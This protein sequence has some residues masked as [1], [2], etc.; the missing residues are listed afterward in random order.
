MLFLF[1]KEKIYS[2]FIAASAVVVLFVLS[3]YFINTDMKILEVSS[4]IKNVDEHKFKI[5][6]WGINTSNYDG[7]D[8]KQILDKINQEL[9]EGNIILMYNETDDKKEQIESTLKWLKDNGV[10]VEN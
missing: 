2:Y 10:N 5:I 8:S 3:F 9:K 7:L 6:P 1:N 4:E